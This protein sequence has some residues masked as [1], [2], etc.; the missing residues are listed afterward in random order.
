[1][2]AVR[3]GRV[4]LV[5][6]ATLAGAVAVAASAHVRASGLPA[7]TDGYARWE[8][9]NRRPLTAPGA[10]DGMKNVYAS[11][12]RGPRGRFPEGTVIVKSIVQPGRTGPPGQVAV[13]RK[14]RGTWRW[15]EYTRSNGRYEV[16]ARGGVCT[17]CH[18]QARAADWV[19]TR[20]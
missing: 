19:F 20:R 3:P 11:R 18:M 10:H 8:K 2:R 15:V 16:L 5:V 13:M 9:L 7:Y 6:A 1:M 4:P 14:V 12:R 17:S